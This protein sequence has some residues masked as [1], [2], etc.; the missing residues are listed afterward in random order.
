LAGGGAIGAD[1]LLFV[2]DHEDGAQDVPAE[3]PGLWSVGNQAYDAS[4]RQAG[5]GADAVEL[6]VRFLETR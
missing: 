2:A 4:E 1:F 3:T 5:Q 6:D